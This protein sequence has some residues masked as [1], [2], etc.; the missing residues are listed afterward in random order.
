MISNQSGAFFRL[1]PFPTS[2]YLLRRICC[3]RGLL[4][5][6]RGL[7]STS[8]VFLLLALGVDPFLFLRR[9]LGF[10]FWRSIAHE[11]ETKVKRKTDQL[12]D[13]C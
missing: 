6:L 9:L 10:G 2:T 5:S 4:L 1:Q 11:R 7:L 13:L 12:R 3:S 8:G